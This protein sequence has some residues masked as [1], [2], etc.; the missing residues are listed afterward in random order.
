MAREPD[1]IGGG[2]GRKNP[3]KKA[4][5]YEPVVRR[6]EELLR[7]LLKYCREADF[8]NVRALI[9]PHPHLLCLLDRYGQ[10][11]LHHAV[12]SGNAEFVTRLMAMYNDPRN[13][14]SK[15]VEY[16]EAAQVNQEEL[17]FEGG[18]GEALVVSAVRPRSW[19]HR[20]G[21]RKGDTL[22]AIGN[23][24]VQFVKSNPKTLL[25][26]VHASGFPAVLE[27]RGPACAEILDSKGWTPLHSAAARGQKVY[28]A[29]LK[30][31][32]PS[33]ADYVEVKDSKG[34]TPQHWAK[35]ANRLDKASGAKLEARSKT[36]PSSAG[37]HS[38]LRGQ[39]IDGTHYRPPGWPQNWK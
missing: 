19:A 13:F 11:A 27:F 25:A 15:V 16:T 29:M 37:T 33:D 17:Q 34:W 21:V 7:Q 5:L 36:R 14:A 2:L 8:R 12:L 4:G 24:T 3:F 6:D 18:L 20:A 22:H 23:D 32:T 38:A 1:V 9:T 28:G 35:L 30:L 26:E 31:T 39:R 10:T